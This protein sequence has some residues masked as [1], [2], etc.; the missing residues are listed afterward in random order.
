M[1]FILEN[2]LAFQEHTVCLIELALNGDESIGRE[3][4]LC[5]KSLSILFFSRVSQN[6]IDDAFIN[7]TRILTGL[8]RIVIDGTSIG[9]C[10]FASELLFDILEEHRSRFPSSSQWRTI[11]QRACLPIVDDLWGQLHAKSDVLLSQVCKQVAMIYAK[12]YRPH[13]EPDFDPFLQ[14]LASF[15]SSDSEHLGKAVINSIQILMPSCVSPRLMSLIEQASNS[16][17]V[18]FSSTDPSSLKRA[19]HSLSLHLSLLQMLNNVLVMCDDTEFSSLVAAANEDGLKRLFACLHRSYLYAK[20]FNENTEL[21]TR[22][23]KAGFMSEL[24][25][26][27]LIKQE[28]C[29]VLTLL[30]AQFRIVI[31]GFLSER[32][33]FLHLALEVSEEVL[34]RYIEFLKD[35]KMHAVDL[36]SWS[37]VVQAIC[38]DFSKLLGSEYPAFT[39]RLPLFCRKALAII[40]TD[41]MSVR[42]AALL[43]VS[44]LTEGLFE[45]KK[46]AI[47]VKDT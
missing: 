42:H 18:S 24:K 40:P 37:I 28:T 17:L 13:L 9:V 35:P 8:S 34:N 43:F 10:M 25:D 21:R 30:S 26:V 22:L 7:C 41:D 19:A 14:H 12:H 32:V 6:L 39:S 3:A 44:N 36:F 27:L 15:L 16:S 4:V 46:D 5:F 29:S 20:H 47:V 38:V 33:S 11:I 2:I 31:G 23:W 45:G 1:P